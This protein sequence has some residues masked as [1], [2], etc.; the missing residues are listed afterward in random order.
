M[1]Q[2]DCKA[3]DTRL[4]VV[5]LE[6]GDRAFLPPFQSLDWLPEKRVGTAALLIQGNSQRILAADDCHWA[7]LPAAVGVDTSS[8]KVDLRGP[9][10]VLYMSLRND[11]K[12]PGM[13]QKIS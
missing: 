2:R 7:A 4:E 10:I 11:L 6:Q 9:G 3:P 12:Q 1:V 13:I 8:R 5:K